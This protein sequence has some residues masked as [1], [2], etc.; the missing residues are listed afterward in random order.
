MPTFRDFCLR[1][2][3]RYDFSDQIQVRY[4]HTNGEEIDTWVS[5][6]EA[7][8]R[9][10]AT[11]REQQIK[12]LSQ[13]DWEMI[14]DARRKLPDEGKR[15]AEEYG[16]E[17]L[18]DMVEDFIGGN[19]IGDS[20]SDAVRGGTRPDDLYAAERQKW[21]DRLKDDAF[22]AQV[23]ELA[24]IQLEGSFPDEDEASQEPDDWL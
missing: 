24:Y 6:T 22:Y 12:G 20:L 7:W 8:Q 21:L 17:Q 5:G 3:L 13:F 9:L 19:V 2:K 4:R 11:A 10:H 1:S 14:R 16:R 23:L 15:W 18:G